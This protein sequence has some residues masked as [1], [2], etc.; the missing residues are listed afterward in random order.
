VTVHT[1]KGHDRPG[2][3][4]WGQ[5]WYVWNNDGDKATL[6]NKVGKL[7]DRCRWGDGDGST[8]C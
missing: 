4:Y 6:R 1:G 7:I 3:R 8:S 2:Q 5:G